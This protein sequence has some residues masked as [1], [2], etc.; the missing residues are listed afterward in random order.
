MKNLLE[1]YSSSHIVYWF[2]LF[3][4]RKM[5]CRKCN[6]KSIAL[7]WRLVMTGSEIAN[8]A[9]FII[10]GTATVGLPSFAQQQ[11]PGVPDFSQ[12]KPMLEMP[13]PLLMFDGQKVKNSIQW[14]KE[15]RPELKRLFQHF[16]YGYFPPK[17][18]ILAK[19]ERED[20]HCFG[21]KATLREV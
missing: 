6:L 17:V 20:A 16:M 5:G 2:M 12:L 11:S 15:R 4:C 7:A 9:L 3:P 10:L 14:T 18:K 19:V 21:G 8:L 13:D 1:T